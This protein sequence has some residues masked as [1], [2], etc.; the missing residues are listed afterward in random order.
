MLGGKP[1]YA[2]F[3]VGYHD[4]N[5][6][7][8]AA[9]IRAAA[10]KAKAAVLEST[11]ELMQSA[12]SASLSRRQSE[13]GSASAGIGAGASSSRRGSSNNT[14][15]GAGGG[16]E[17]PRN[18]DDV[19]VCSSTYARHVDLLGLDP[20]TTFSNPTVNVLDVCEFPTPEHVSQVS[21]EKLFV[22]FLFAHCWPLFLSYIHT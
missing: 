22:S 4:K 11:S 21:K 14:G 18:T 10:S 16:T 8:A 6:R 12:S 1:N 5:R 19:P 2:R 3:F 7:T 17:E 9:I 13:G 20:H 15:A